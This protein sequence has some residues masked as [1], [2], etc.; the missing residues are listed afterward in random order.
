MAGLMRDQNL[1][2]VEVHRFSNTPVEQGESLYWDFPQLKQ[3]I[4]LGLLQLAKLADSLGVPVTSLG[5]DTWAVDYGLLDLDGNLLE[6]PRHYRDSRNSVGVASVRQL[7]SDPDLYGINGMQFLPFNTLYQLSAQRIQQPQLL[8]QATTVLLIPDLLVHWLTGKAATERTNASTTGLVNAQ[9]QEWDWGLID[10]LGLQRSW[11][12]TI[13]DPGQQVGKLLPEHVSHPALQNTVI[14]AVASHD[15]ASAVAGAPMLEPR[16]AYLSSGTWSLIGVELGNANLSELARQQ[17]FTN[18]IGVEHRIRFLKNLSGLWLLQQSL[19]QFQMEDPSVTL[20]Q[21]LTEAATVPVSARINVADD[22]FIAPG[23]MPERIRAYCVKLGFQA[24]QSPAELVRCILES[25]ALAYAEALTA[26]EEIV[27]YKIERLHVVGGGSQNQLLCQLT[28]NASQI[29][30]ISGPVEATAIGNLMIQSGSALAAPSAL[31]DQRRQIAASF[32]PV[33][34]LPAQ[35][36][37]SQ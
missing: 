20:Q 8:A 3:Q 25:L 1:E 37:S 24:P 5:V 12:T 29:P 21:L 26:L 6:Q 18:E 32:Q 28:A 36:E 34:Y 13:L 15:T 4:T 33:T 31:I 30:V 11:F 10:L 9:T 7:I 14:T 16:S 19:E 2:V 17:N 23:N 27:G 35:A 22:A